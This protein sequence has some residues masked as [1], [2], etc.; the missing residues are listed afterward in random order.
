MSRTMITAQQAIF[1]GLDE[2][3]AVA[4]EPVTNAGAP[5]W[6]HGTSA[7]S[8]FLAGAQV[9]YLFRVAPRRIIARLDYENRTF[10]STLGLQGGRPPTGLEVGDATPGLVSVLLAEGKPRPTATPYEIKDAVE[11]ADFTQDPSY[12]GHDHK[13]IASLFGPIQVFE[14]GP[15]E[16]SE[17]WRA[18][19]E[20]CLGQVPGMD[21]WIEE[22]TARSLLTL[23]DLSG[24]GLP[25]QILC[26]SLFDVDPA[27]LFLALYRCLEAL[28]A[29]TASTKVATALQFSGSWQ[30]VAIALEREIGWRPR[31]EDSLAGLFARST[32][33][34]LCGIFDCLG[35]AQ[36]EDGST[37]PAMA[38]KRTYKLRNSLVHYRP[39]H[40]TV[41]HASIEWN[42]LCKTLSQLIREIY[43]DVFTAIDGAATGEASG[44]GAVQASAADRP[45]SNFD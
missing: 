13:V 44:E 15:I 29:F 45:A 42:Q 31:E 16:P 17:T 22:E 34:T 40:H 12:E 4:G 36:P 19:Y 21:T 3:C 10:F 43:F 30:E 18:Y 37:M 1:S 11:L 14:G 25:Y 8:A 35:E 27:G 2:M 20:I 24:L 28:Y 5:R 33:I 39:I 41:E 23:T 6:I 32:E 9:S 7:D 38:A 26:R